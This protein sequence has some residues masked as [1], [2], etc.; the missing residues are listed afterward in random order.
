M[1]FFEDETNCIIFFFLLLSDTLAQE[2]TSGI[3]I[4]YNLWSGSSHVLQTRNL[5][6]ELETLILIMLKISEN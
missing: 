1:I 5:W 2:I 6:L 3:Y 4:F